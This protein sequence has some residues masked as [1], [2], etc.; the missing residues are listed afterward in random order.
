MSNFTSVDGSTL[1]NDYKAINPISGQQ[2]QYA[3][4]SEEERNKGFIR[5]LRLAY[6]HV[7]PP[8]P[9]N[10]RDLTE[11]EKLQ[12]SNCNYVKY[13]QYD[14]DQFPV[15]G[16]FIKQEDLDRLN[17]GCGQP[18]TMHE[19]IAATYARQPDF[20]GSTHC[21]HC[22]KAFPVGVGGEFVWENTD[23]RVGT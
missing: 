6:V 15:V 14:K 17:K 20:Y 13:E 7:G 2:K 8:L 18:T 21:A 5:P 3:V 23:F 22:K 1:V 16:R 4:L 11:E 9:K 19:N 12:Y 10:L